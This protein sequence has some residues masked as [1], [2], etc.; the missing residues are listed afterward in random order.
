MPAVSKL[1]F[2]NDL[3]N[4]IEQEIQLFWNG[5]DDLQKDMTQWKSKERREKEESLI[6]ELVGHLAKD[7]FGALLP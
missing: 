7:L 2:S 1:A 4:R 5:L 6:I 3:I